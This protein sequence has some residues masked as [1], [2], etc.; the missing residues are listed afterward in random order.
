MIQ[1]LKSKI[2]ALN[3]VSLSLADFACMEPLGMGSG[4]ISSDQISAS[5]Q[6]NSNWSPERSRL[7]YQENGWTPSDDTVREWIQVS[8][9]WLRQKSRNQFSWRILE[10]KLGQKNEIMSHIGPHFR[11]WSQNVRSSAHSLM[12][13]RCSLWTWLYCWDLAHIWLE[14]CSLIC[15]TSL[16]VTHRMK[17]EKPTC[18]IYWNLPLQHSWHFIFTVKSDVSRLQSLNVFAALCLIS[19][20]TFGIFCCMAVQFDKLTAVGLQVWEWGV[21]SNTIQC[22]LTKHPKMSFYHLLSGLWLY[23]LHMQRVCI[24]SYLLFCNSYIHRLY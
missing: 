12:E 9:V 6:Y 8:I 16:H 4:E 20:N 11:V 7:N 15:T 23:K 24:L 19:L 10:V 14:Y 1:N 21:S 18:I 5:S 13:K 3:G 17:G 2:W 22:D